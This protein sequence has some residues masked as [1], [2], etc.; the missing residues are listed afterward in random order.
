MQSEPLESKPEKNVIYMFTSLF[1]CDAFIWLCSGEQNAPP[2]S[3]KCTSPHIRV[4][5]WKAGKVQRAATRA[6][7]RTKQA[8]MTTDMTGPAQSSEAAVQKLPFSDRSIPK[9]VYVISLPYIIPFQFLVGFF[10]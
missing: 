6:H 4:H 8:L 5:M 10:F 9:S 2:R 1:G 7:Q 3:S